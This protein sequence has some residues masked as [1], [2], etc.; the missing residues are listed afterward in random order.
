MTKPLKRRTWIARF[1]TMAS[2]IVAGKGLDAQSSGPTRRKEIFIAAD[3]HTDYMWTADEETYRQAFLATIDHYLNLADK[4]DAE[5]NDFQ[6]RWNCD[7]LFWFWEYQKN[8]NAADIKRL[9]ARIKS[10]H[11]SFPMTML[12]SC[13]GGAPTEAVL[14]GLYYA[15]HL[16]RRFGL[17]FP[18]AVSM[19]NQ[20]L[21]LG[22]AT[23][24]SGSGV[25]YSWKGIC[26]CASKLNTAGDRQHDVYW[27]RATDGSRIL[28][29][30]YSLIAPVRDGTYSNEGPGGYA[31]ARYPESAIR[32]VES[33]ESFLRK[34]PQHVIGLF[35]QGWDDL[36][37]IVPLEDSKR[38]FPAVAKRMSNAQRRVVVSNELD[39]F[40]TFEREYGDSIPEVSEA[41]GNE[42]ELY[43]ASLAEVSSSV[44]RATE[45]LRTAEAMAAVVSTDLPNAFDDLRDARDEAWV[46]LGLYWEHDW[47]A[48]G[49]VTR[50]QRADWQRRVAEKVD[51]YVNDLSQRASRLLVELLRSPQ[52]QDS[53]ILFNSL[54]YTRDEW[55]EWE[56]EPGKILMPESGI[57]HSIAVR[58]RRLVLRIQANVPACG[59]KKIRL[60]PM[61]GYKS[62]AAHVESWVQEIDVVTSHSKIRWNSDGEIYSWRNLNSN[63]ELVANGKVLNGFVGVD[64]KLVRRGASLGKGKVVWQNETRTVLRFEIAGKH[65]RQV[66]VSVDHLTDTV[67]IENWIQH[68]FSELRAW[69]FG[70]ELVQP[71]VVHEEV[72]A[73]LRAADVSAGG[74]YAGRNA[75]TD[76]LTLNHFVAADSRH[77]MVSLS[78]WDCSFFHLGDGRLDSP[79]DPDSAVISVL[80]GGQVDGPKLGIPNQGGDHLF[81]QRF[82]IHH[83]SDRV[84][85]MKRALEHQNPIAVVPGTA[86][87]VASAGV[88]STPGNIRSHGD[89]FSLFRLESDSC[90]IWAVK[91]AEEGAQQG[92]I[93]RIWNLSDVDSPYRLFCSRPIESCFEC[94]HIETNRGKMSHGDTVIDE[95][96]PGHA[97][98]TL[99]VTFR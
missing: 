70:F 46:A 79:M 68:N 59:F 86:S 66:N 6:S 95:K 98:R 58:D 45:R 78:N 3:D 13:Y 55:V 5:P 19:E 49:P 83:V 25:R 93:V 18:M 26:G 76:W 32:F 48:D 84:E 64:G 92:M 39:F 9:V 15:G 61:T 56:M 4:T 29:K 41:Y 36:T 23:L 28:M 74:H 35:G 71:R 60:M 20:T 47:T 80:A 54:G 44:R 42:W 12:V 85:A 73:L 88:N 43:S 82:A 97:M 27:W 67:E 51:R 2:A 72:G 75:R 17:R 89:E 96:L 34:N 33:D 8:R 62:P 30:W 99:R 81:R 21:P 22:L 57:P 37:T 7:G 77:R 65:P 31:E 91:V 50:N 38:S 40:D 16:E 10:G 24:W 11:I 87:V 53:L 14:R 63:E 69:Q 1:A 52:E 94:S 90:Q